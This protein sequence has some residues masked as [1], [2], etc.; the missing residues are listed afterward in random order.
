MLKAKPAATNST[1]IEITPTR[2]RSEERQKNIHTPRKTREYKYEGKQLRGY[3]KK[4][5][6]I[7]AQIKTREDTRYPTWRHDR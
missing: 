2:T 5:K 6:K 1:R 7:T 3:R 4:K